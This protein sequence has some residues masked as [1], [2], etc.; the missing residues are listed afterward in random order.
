[1]GYML[2]QQF[3]HKIHWVSKHLNSMVLWGA[4]SKRDKYID[5]SYRQC[6]SSVYRFYAAHIMFSNLHLLQMPIYLFVL[7]I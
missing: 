3:V 5:L 4:H 1:M 6:F 2:L 7:R